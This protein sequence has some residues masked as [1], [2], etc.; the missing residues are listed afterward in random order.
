MPVGNT[1][2]VT[3][4]SPVA[5]SKYASLLIVGNQALEPVD[6]EAKN[7][8]GATV[9]E[10]AILGETQDM[11]N[12]SSA[13]LAKRMNVRAATGLADSESFMRRRRQLFV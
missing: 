9:A 13:G 1:T 8:T 7:G 4:S 6:V 12:S 5:A 11:N 2:N 10:W 3:L